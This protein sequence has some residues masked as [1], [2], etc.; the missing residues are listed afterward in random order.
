MWSE[1]GLQIQELAFIGTS[2][3]CGSLALYF[4]NRSVDAEQKMRA[5]QSIVDH[6]Q[7]GYYHSSLDGKQ[8]C[9]NPAL[10]RLNGYATEAELLESVKDIA[11]EWY[12]D[13]S[14]RDDFRKELLSNGKVTNFVSEI[15]RHKSRERIW[16]SENARLVHDPE[17][18]EPLYY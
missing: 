13:P 11:I 16:I 9:A 12:V 2:A 8:L 18:V 6:L 4:Y 10:V 3:I 14:R 1:A 15:Y 17:T 5:C 7:E